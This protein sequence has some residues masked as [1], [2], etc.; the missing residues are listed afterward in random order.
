MRER[1]RSFF[2]R[3]LFQ[4]VAVCCSVSQCFFFEAYPV[5]V[6]SS[7]LQCVAGCCSVLQCAI[8][9]CSAVQCVVILR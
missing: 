4:C 9:L 5:A 3:V 6:C 2:K 1:L 8:V 7:V